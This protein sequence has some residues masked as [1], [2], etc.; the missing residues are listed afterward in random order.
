M[1]EEKDLHNENN[2]FN[3][4]FEKPESNGYT[5]QDTNTCDNSAAYTEN[6]DEASSTSKAEN[7]TEDNDFTVDFSLD[8]D[9]FQSSNNAGVDDCDFASELE[10]YLPT[11]E[12]T[13]KLKKPVPSWLKTAAVSA[14]VS[15]LLFGI[16]SLTVI[17]HIKPTAVISY[18]QGNKAESTVSTGVVA[19]AEKI[20]PSIVSVSGVSSYRSFFGLSSSETSGT[21]VIISADGYI[22]TSN[23]LVGDGSNIKVTLQ[24]KTQYDAILVGNDKSKDIAIL[25]IDAKNLP[26]TSL[27]DSDA[28][29]T[30][31]AAIVMGNLLGNDMGV[32][33]TQG[34]ICGINKNLALQNGNTLN[35]FQTDAITTSN[36]TG[37]CLLNQNGD[38][39]GMV[40]HAISSDIDSISFAIP[41][42]DIKNT[43]QSLIND[44][45]PAKSDSLIIGITGT[46]SEHGVI[47]E[48]VLDDTP[49]KKADIKAGD[50]IL[51]ADG[52][53]VKSI[54]EINK[55]RD[56]HVSGEKIILTIY[57][58]GETLDI[59]II[60]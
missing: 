8:Y 22:L 45:I 27:S 41:A 33:A 25:Q 57:R 2:D 17:P 47:V 42:N 46:D 34:I 55:I 18:V 50:L 44:S 7:Y 24:D 1:S 14:A 6:H 30:G 59:E 32:S 15:I 13:D 60:L 10:N 40:T 35:L 38:I 3:S 43:T 12:N 39:I 54:A 52:K 31:D 16:Y 19:I 58:N 11:D 53:A 49:A 9:D 23:A 51:K 36:S 28:V 5:P 20:T 48:S 29:K 26:A 37:G 21:G 4:S 56:S